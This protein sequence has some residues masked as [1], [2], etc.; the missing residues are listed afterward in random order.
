[1]GQYCALG[2]L[3][4]VRFSVIMPWAWRRIKVHCASA[5]YRPT[6]DL[7]FDSGMGHRTRAIT[8]IDVISLVHRV[9]SRGNNLTWNAEC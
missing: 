2:K 6:P 8:E 9:S 1:M 3:P 4:M 5:L 7:G